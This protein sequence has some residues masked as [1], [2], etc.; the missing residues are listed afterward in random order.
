MVP[1]ARGPLCPTSDTRQHWQETSWGSQEAHA[2]LWPAAAATFPPPPLRATGPPNPAR[3]AGEPATKRPARPMAHWHCSSV[4]SPWCFP[5]PPAQQNHS[6]CHLLWATR[7][8][9]HAPACLLFLVGAALMPMAGAGHGSEPPTPCPLPP[10][11]SILGT[12]THRPTQQ[13]RGQW[14]RSPAG[15]NWPCSISINRPDPQPV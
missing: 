3:A 14:A 9:S 8:A 6:C 13:K 11:K 12:T 15:V 4:H 2:P 7:A 5:L 10:K 1:L